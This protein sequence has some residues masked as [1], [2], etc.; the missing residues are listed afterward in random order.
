MQTQSLT[1]S[2]LDSLSTQELES[3]GTDLNA[4][5]QS[6]S[7]AWL[8]YEPTND[9]GSLKLFQQW[10]ANERAAIAERNVLMTRTQTGEK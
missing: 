9:H 4:A 8:Q 1:P 3:L 6:Q 2:S 5:M 7:R 10:S